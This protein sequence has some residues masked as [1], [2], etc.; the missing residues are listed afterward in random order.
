MQ[1]RSYKT[2]YIISCTDY[3]VDCILMS[4][5]VFQDQVD[6]C[7]GPRKKKKRSTNVLPTTRMTRS[8]AFQDSQPLEETPPNGEDIVAAQN[9][10]TQNLTSKDSNSPDDNALSNINSQRTL[11][12]PFFY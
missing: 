9:S 4:S 1:T 10:P 12:I 6:G 11:I 7:T 8:T 5:A 2:T 3:N